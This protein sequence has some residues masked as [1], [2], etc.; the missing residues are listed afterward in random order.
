MGQDT[1]FWIADMARERAQ[2]DRDTLAILARAFD[3]LVTS[4]SD[5]ALYQKELATFLDLV[6]L[7]VRDVPRG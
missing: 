3:R 5:A 4:S 7:S 2:K 1:R 6:A